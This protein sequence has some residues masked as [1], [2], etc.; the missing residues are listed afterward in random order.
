MN[1]ITHLLLGW[2]V[3]HAGGLDAK[4]RNPVAWAGL[5]PDLDGLGLLV[6]VGNGVLG[7]P[8]SFH[9]ATHHH[10]L[11]HGI[12]GAAV[13]TAAI[14]AV[15]TRR[16]RTS[17]LALAAFHLHLLCDLAGSRGPTV[18]D[19]WPIHY[20]GPFSDR[21]T[22]S[23]SHQWAV[24]GWPNIVVTLSL[25]AIL[26]ERAVRAGVTPVGLFGARAEMAFVGAVRAR[27]QKHRSS[28]GRLEGRGP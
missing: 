15:A 9:Y 1:P 25:L 22:F 20:L 27:W 12:F 10:V 17:I 4:D 28:A 6:D 11:F 21:L 16:V 24:N 8:E 7:R 19:I 5:A 3:G 23:W 13:T 18:D 2:E 26:F 14:A